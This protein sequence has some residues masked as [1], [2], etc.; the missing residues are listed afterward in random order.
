MQFDTPH[1]AASEAITSDA[2]TVRPA[3]S[4]GRFPWRGGMMLLGIIGGVTFGML[5]WALLQDPAGPWRRLADGSEVRVVGVTY[6]TRHQVTEGR[7]WQRLLQPLTPP[8]APLR[9]AGV[10]GWDGVRNQSALP[11]PGVPTSVP[12]RFGGWQDHWDTPVPELVVWVRHRTAAKAWAA[13]HFDLKDE[14]GCRFSGVSQW[15]RSY[16]SEE[17]LAATRFEVFPRHGGLVQLISRVPGQ[18]SVNPLALTVRTP[19]AGAQPEWQPE[20]I[21]QTQTR[22]DLAFRFLGWGSGRALPIGRFEV[23][24]AGQP[25]RGWEPVTVTVSDATGNSLTTVRERESQPDPTRLVFPGLCRQEPAWKLRVE[26]APA[27]PPLPAKT[28]PEPGWSPAPAAPPSWT[29]KTRIPAPRSGRRF[30]QDV[31]LTRPDLQLEIVSVAAKG[32]YSDDE[33]DKRPLRC[34]SILVRM[35]GTREPVRL[36]LAKVTDEQGRSAVPR[37]QEKPLLTRADPFRPRPSHLFR[38]VAEDRTFVLPDLPGAK[39]LQLE[40]VAHRVVPVDFVVKPPGA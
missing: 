9:P 4:K 13:P 16:S 25:D 20:A 28:S 34:P 26:F 35:K 40:F 27:L 32:A 18:Q 31:R 3:P 7:V 1:V 22:G 10:A 24:R 19:D 12:G 36:T 8:G 15:L 39:S 37:W 5:T 33:R 17:Q 23:L 2:T 11:F 6:G 14:H 38:P 30:I 21:P 29:W